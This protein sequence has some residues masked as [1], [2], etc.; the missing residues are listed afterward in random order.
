MAVPF[1]RCSA[2]PAMGASP[3]SDEVAS[4]MSCVRISRGSKSMDELT[5][6]WQDWPA[7]TP[8][9]CGSRSGSGSG[10]NCSDSRVRL[11]WEPIS[12]RVSRPPSTSSS[13]MAIDRWATTAS[14]ILRKPS[15]QA[16]SPS[17]R[18]S[19]CECSP[20]GPDRRGCSRRIAKRFDPS[21]GGSRR[22]RTH[23]AAGVVQ[24]TGGWH[25]AMATTRLDTRG[26]PRV[27]HR[28]LT[29]APGSCGPA[30]DEGFAA[31]TRPDRLDGR[32]FGDRSDLVCHERPQP[33]RRVG[34]GH[35]FRG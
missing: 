27:G 16:G 20:T 13:R 9:R 12:S 11:T 15:K 17:I 4:P 10:S 14:A 35:G 24:G 6:S 5:G 31:A 8:S 7:L 34:R 1:E 25:H 32:D 28:H 23:Q 18:R 2:L 3:S 21:P 29:D 33:R 19:G 26:T 30:S 22:R